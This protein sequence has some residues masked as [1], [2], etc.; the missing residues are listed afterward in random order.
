LFNRPELQDFKILETSSLGIGGEAN[1]R[2]FSLS[3]IAQS[4]QTADSY[5]QK[6]LIADKDQ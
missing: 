6:L 4:L 2:P 3:S 5:K 1:E